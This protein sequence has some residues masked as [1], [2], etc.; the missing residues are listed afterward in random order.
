MGANEKEKGSFVVLNDKGLHTRPATELVRCAQTF[1]A[2]VFLAYRG[3]N[4]NAKSLLGI[5]MLAATRG[6]KIDIEAEG[7]DAKSAVEALI[8]LSRNRFNFKF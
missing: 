1:K 2:Q 4:V 8:S 6:A 5:L 7:V 3:L